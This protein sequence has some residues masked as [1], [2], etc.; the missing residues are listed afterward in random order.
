MGA[1]VPAT[2]RHQDCLSAF[3]AGHFVRSKTRKN[4][5]NNFANF[6]ISW[7]AQYKLTERVGLTY[8]NLVVQNGFV[9]T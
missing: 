4:L 9:G 6:A 8:S 1:D 5:K 2:A 3:A 7:R